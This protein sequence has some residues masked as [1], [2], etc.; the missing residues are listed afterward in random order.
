MKEGKE[1]E[2]MTYINKSKEK[3]LHK[4]HLSVKIHRKI[5]Y[6]SKKSGKN[7]LSRT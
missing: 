3:K 1:N 2:F 5:T 7:N 4:Y 6:T